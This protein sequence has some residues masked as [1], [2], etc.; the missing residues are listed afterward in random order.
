MHQL[1]VCK[2]LPLIYSYFINYNRTIVNI[3]WSS[4]KTSDI[5]TWGI[6]LFYSAPQSNPTV[7]FVWYLPN[8]AHPHCC[9]WTD[10]SSGEFMCNFCLYVFR[11]GSVLCRQISGAWWVTYKRLSCFTGEDVGNQIPTWPFIWYAR[12]T[13]LAIASPVP[14]TMISRSSGSYMTAG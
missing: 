13:Q 3:R 12:R 11:A 8:G 4:V 2:W 5:C 6:W 1:A 7:Q 14:M 9:H 10:M